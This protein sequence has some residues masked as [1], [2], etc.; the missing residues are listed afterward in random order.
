MVGFILLRIGGNQNS[1]QR[2][3]ARKAKDNGVL[4]RTHFSLSV[5]LRLGELCAFAV[6]LVRFPTGEPTRKHPRNQKLLKSVGPSSKIS[7]SGS[8]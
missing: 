5:P 2:R 8:N 1:P 4:N 7:P 6:S 3:Q